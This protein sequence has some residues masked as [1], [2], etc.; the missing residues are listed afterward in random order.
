MD[1]LPAYPYPAPTPASPS[2]P[3]CGGVSI[4]NDAC[5]NPL[6]C[7][8]QYGYYGTGAEYSNGIPLPAPPG[9]IPVDTSCATAGC[10][11]SST[12]TVGLNSG[13]HVMLTEQATT[14]C[15]QTILQ[16]T[17]SPK[18]EYHHTVRSL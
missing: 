10:A 4:G 6:Y 17:L 16:G 9:P 1:P 14:S 13:K 12:A 3:A 11:F 7:C 5:P 15:A 18:W 8:S 2:K